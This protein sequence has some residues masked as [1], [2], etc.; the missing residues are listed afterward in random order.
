ML[1]IACTVFILTRKATA[2][3]W[4]CGEF[5]PCAYR[6]EISR[7][8]GPPYLSCWAGYLL[9][10]SVNFRVS[11]GRGRPACGRTGQHAFRHEQRV[12]A[13]CSFSGP[14]P[15]GK[16]AGTGWAAGRQPGKTIA[17][18]G[19]GAVGA[20]AFTSPIHSGFPPWKASS[21]AIS[22]LSSPWPLGDREMGRT[23]GSAAGGV[24]GS[25]LPSPM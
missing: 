3:F 6:L 22:P 23:G 11:C 9:F 7:P 10:F 16:A 2:S 4:D 17:I 19:A 1:V 13:S 5:I 18:I 25:S 20:L 12:P 24:A 21:S 8:P 14:L 15:P